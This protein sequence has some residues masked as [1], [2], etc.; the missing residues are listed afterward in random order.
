MEVRRHDIFGSFGHLHTFM[1]ILP[2]GWE[3][4]YV[5]C[6]RFYVFVIWCAK[7]CATTLKII[8]KIE[9][10]REESLTGS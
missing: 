6:L 10:E 5:T 9:Q 1:R 8:I 2:S 7:Q 3:E 4:Y